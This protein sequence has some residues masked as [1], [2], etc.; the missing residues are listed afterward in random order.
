MCSILG[1]WWAAV[2][3]TGRRMPSGL[4][5][6]KW[7]KSRRV[8]RIETVAWLSALF[9]AIT[10]ANEL[11]MSNPWATGVFVGVVMV[12][13]NGLPAFVITLLHNGKSKSRFPA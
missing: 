12:I 5:R 13:V 9:G 6:H 7:D 2:D 10:V 4:Q 8:R 11:W 3:Y 1:A